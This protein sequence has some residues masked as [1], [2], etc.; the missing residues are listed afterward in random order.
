MTRIEI[1]ASILFAI[2]FQLNVDIIFDL[3]YGLYGYFEK[4][5]Q[6]R[7]F[8]IIL[9]IFPAVN[10][11]VLNYF[12]YGK[13]TKSKAYYILGWSVF[14]VTFEWASVKAGI[15]YHDGGN[16][17]TPLSLILQFL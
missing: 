15:F 7:S 16:Y 10:T 3:K 13:K 12:P 1:Y 14:L 2:V 6:W 4:G 9:G 5:I 17:G 11:I 8:L